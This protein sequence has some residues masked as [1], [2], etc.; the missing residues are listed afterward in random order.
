MAGPGEG[1][2]PPDSGFN[3]TLLVIL[4]VVGFFVLFLVGHAAMYF[5]A[6]SVMPPKKKKPVSQRKLKRE[7]LKQGVSIPGE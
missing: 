5:Y 7:R 4:V 2:T 1:Q 3:P 6:Q